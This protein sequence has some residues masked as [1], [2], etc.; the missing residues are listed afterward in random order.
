[1]KPVDVRRKNDQ[2]WRDR[3]Q[4]LHAFKHV[5]AADLLDELLEKAKGELFGDEIRHQK[6]PSLRP[7]TTLEFG[8]EIR[9]DFSLLEL[10]REFVPQR[11]IRRLHHFEYLSG[12]HSL[13]EHARFVLQRQLSWVAALHEPREHLL[14]QRAA[15]PELLVEMILNEASESVVESVRERE[16]RASFTSKICLRLKRVR[17]NLCSPNRQ[18]SRRARRIFQPPLFPRPFCSEDRKRRRIFQLMVNTRSRRNYC[19]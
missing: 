15:R 14:N 7:R 12:Q 3:G 11:H 16:W 18:Q 8:C 17:K 4:R 13:R 6:S 19:R 10:A 1:M 2:N 9:F 5:S